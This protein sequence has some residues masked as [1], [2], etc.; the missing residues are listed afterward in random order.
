MIYIW[1]FMGLKLISLFVGEILVPFF[2]SR[3]RYFF[4]SSA[5]EDGMEKVQLC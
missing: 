3:S 5:I 2:G 4:A 1:A